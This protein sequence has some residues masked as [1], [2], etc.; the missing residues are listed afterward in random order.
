MKYYTGIGSRET[1]KHICEM[2]TKIATKLEAMGYIL[3]SG[4]ASGADTAFEDGV[5]TNKEI[6][7]PWNDFNG[8][9]S[10]SNGIYLY[11]SLNKTKEAN[12]IAKTLHPRF[13]YLTHGAKKLHTRNVHQV[14]GKDL[15]TPS[16]FVILYSE[17]TSDGVKGGTNT[18]Y[19]LAKRN[20]IPC[21]NLYEAGAIIRLTKFIKD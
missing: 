14:L 12:D 3:R 16:K 11:E 9:N 20:N 1:P 6:Y 15:E 4:G 21:F 17:T 18:A 2:M 13:D 10:S 8:R 19:Q 5:E 7:I